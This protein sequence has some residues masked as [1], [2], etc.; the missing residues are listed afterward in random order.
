MEEEEEEG[1]VILE[2]ICSE[3]LLLCLLKGEA[4]HTRS[5]FSLDNKV[6]GYW[7]YH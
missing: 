6:Q 3:P 5:H 2:A 7:S 4:N 1:D